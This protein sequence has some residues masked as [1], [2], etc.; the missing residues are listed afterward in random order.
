M[1]G[2]IIKTNIAKESMI[3]TNPGSHRYQIR[4]VEKYN[5]GVEKHHN[6]ITTQ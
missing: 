4:V 1:V 5:I 2:L 6:Y 3:V